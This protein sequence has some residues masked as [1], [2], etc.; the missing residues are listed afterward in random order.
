VNDLQPVDLQ[1]IDWD[2]GGGLVPAIVQDARDGRVLMLGYMNREALQLTEDTRRVTFYSRSRAR[3]WEKGETSGHGLAL[4]AIRLDCDGD[5]LL[6]SAV[7]EGPVCHTGTA[8]CFGDEAP[9]GLAFLTQLEQLIA[10]RIAENPEGS[11]TA[12]LYRSGVRRVSQKVGE[13]GLEVAIAGCVEGDDALLG[14]SA[15]LLYHLLV[16]LRAR[17]LNFEQVVDLLRSR[18]ESTI[19]TA[20][21]RKL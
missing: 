2:K 16:L 15:D 21:S 9:P 13:E 6:I 7:P 4:R 11:Y 20:G 3:L 1:R 17:S 5:T 10:R 12:R 14:E 19:S 8:T 18:H